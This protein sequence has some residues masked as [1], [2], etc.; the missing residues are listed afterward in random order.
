MSA[1]QISIAAPPYIQSCARATYVDFCVLEAFL[2]IVIYSLVRYLADE[3]KIRDSNLLLLGALKGSL[4]NLGLSPSAAGCLRSA[5][6]LLAAGALC[7]CLSKIKL[8]LVPEDGKSEGNPYTMV[9]S[10]GLHGSIALAPTA[11]NGEGNF[12]EVINKH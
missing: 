7:Y 11:G 12:G 4:S 6:V 2:Q 3:C 9:F 1:I 8:V 5:S 10:F